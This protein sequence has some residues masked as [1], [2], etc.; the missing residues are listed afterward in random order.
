MIEGWRLSLPLPSHTPRLRRARARRQARRARRRRLGLSLLIQVTRQNGLIEIDPFLTRMRRL[1]R[2]VVTAARMHD[3]E[4]RGQPSQHGDADADLSR[5]R[6]LGAAAHHDSAQVHSLLAFAG[7]AFACA[8]SGWP[9]CSSAAPFTTTSCSG[10]RM[11]CCFPSPTTKDGGPMDQPESNGPA[12]PLDILRSTPPSLT[13]RL[14]LASLLEPDS[15][16]GAASTTSDVRFR[17]GS[18]CP[19]G[20]ERSVTWLEEQCASKVSD[21]LNGKAGFACRRRGGC[22]AVHLALS[23]R[24]ASS[25]TSMPCATWLGHGPKLPASAQR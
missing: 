9:S 4:L 25:P 6:R 10:C 18:T 23:M 15:T 22:P 1:R 2:A 11:A 7:A 8:T 12:S 21:W 17:N 19:T 5:G 16:D 13:R 3:H 24:S 14:E 20:P